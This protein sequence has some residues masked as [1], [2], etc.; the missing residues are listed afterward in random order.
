MKLKEIFY[1]LGLRPSVREYPY[2]L[3]HVH[4]GGDGDVEVAIWR[5]PSVVRRL[6]SGRAVEVSQRSIDVLRAFL[7][8]G[9]VAVDIGA[10]TGDSTLP[11]ALAVGRSGV[12]FAF[13]PNLYAFKVLLANAGLNCTKTHIIPMNLAATPHDGTYEF[14]YSDAGFCNGGFHQGI[15][16]WKHGHFFKLKVTGRHLPTLL[17][18]DFPAESQRIRY[19]KI[20]TEGF[21][22]AVAGSLR[23][24]LVGQRPYLKTEMYKHTPR[25]EREGYYRDLRDLGYTLYRIADDDQDYRTHALD[26]R[27][28]MKWSHFDVFAEPQV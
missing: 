2:D 18:A 14:Q 7:E 24:W 5:H 6:E 13:E 8:P 22:R 1:G 9:D 16:P 12:V 19:V 20:D 15:S 23:D 10:H 28:L 26:E 3:R 17:A 11:I 21:D 25:E 4:L 27:D